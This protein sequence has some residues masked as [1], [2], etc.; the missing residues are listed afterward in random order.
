MINIQTLMRQV[1]QIK[2][3]MHGTDPNAFIQRLMQEGKVTQEEYNAAVK[4]VQDIQRM[5]KK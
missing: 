5:L 1:A 4:Q 2:K 3:Q